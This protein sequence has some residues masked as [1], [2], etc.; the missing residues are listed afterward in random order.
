[1]AAIGWDRLGLG[2]GDHRLSQV[3]RK[4]IAGYRRLS[5]PDRGKNYVGRCGFLWVG[6]PSF[7]KPPASEAVWRSGSTS[8]G[9][10][11]AVVGKIK[12]LLLDTI[13]Y[14]LILVDTR[15][16]GGRGQRSEG[17]GQK[18]EGGDL[19]PGRGCFKRPKRPKTMFPGFFA[20]SKRPRERVGTL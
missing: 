14:Y 7:V 15:F 17:R 16:A 5:Q 2:E 13:G 3:G 12:V 6:G 18:P 11:G 10:D 1:M 20:I 9:G 8:E 4:A 19:L